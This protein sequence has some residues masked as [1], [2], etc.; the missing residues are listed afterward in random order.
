MTKELAIDIILDSLKDSAIVFGLFFVLSVV[1][2]FFEDKIS[3]IL[4]KTG[5][6]SPLFGATFGLIPQCG[7]SVI[8]ADLYVKRHITIGTIVAVF[9]SCSDEALPIIFTSDRWWYG[10]IL[11]GVKF[12]LGFIFGF[13]L[14][15]IMMKGQKQVKEHLEECD[16]QDEE[17][18]HGCCHHDIDNPEENKW[19][20]HLLHPLLHSLKIFAYVLAINLAFGFLVGFIGED[21]IASFLE[22]NKYLTPL[23]TTIIGMIPNCVSSVIVSELFAEGSIAFGALLSGLMMNAGLGIFY[24]LKHKKEWKH[25]LIIIFYCFGASIL[26]GYITS[27][28]IGF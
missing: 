25:N 28:I 9:L 3:K 21:K 17:V 12:V 1:I 4:E 22:M 8:A 5:R 18:H 6:L 24:L 26:S 20:K 11:I 13:L 15:L 7:T 19:H 16:H 2:S 14:D 10:F 23:Y 27:L